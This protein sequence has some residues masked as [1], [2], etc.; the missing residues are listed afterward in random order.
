VWTHLLSILAIIFLRS[1]A[2]QKEGSH[3]SLKKL[4]LVIVCHGAVGKTCLLWA[5]SKQ[6]ILQDN[7]SIVFNNDVVEP[8]VNNEEVMLQF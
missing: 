2:L 1:E 8:H 3:V 6:E 5:Y 7:V 4:G